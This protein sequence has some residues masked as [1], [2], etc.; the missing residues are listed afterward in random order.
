MKPGLKAFFDSMDAFL[1]AG[2]SGL[3]RLRAAHPGWDESPSRV[4]LYGH[5]VRNHI[6]GGL[7]KLRVRLPLPHPTRSGHRT[8]F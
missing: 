6:R 8:L 4:V 5:F 3:Q 2:P 1:T 7:E